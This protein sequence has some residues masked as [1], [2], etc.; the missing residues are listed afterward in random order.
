MLR[1]VLVIGALVVI[2]CWLYGIAQA[3]GFFDRTPYKIHLPNKDSHRELAALR[4][5]VD[6]SSVDGNPSVEAF[7]NPD[8]VNL[9]RALGY[10]VESIPNQAYE[11]FLQLKQETEGS[12]DPMR[13]YHSYEELVAEL[14]AIAS[15]H[16]DLCRAV[17]IGPTVQGRALWFMKISDNVNVEEDEL[18]FL[19]ISSMHGDEVV[20]KE[21]CMYLINLLVDEYGI[22]P[23][24]TEL[25]NETEIWI[26]PSMNPDGTAMGSRYNANGVDLNRNFPDR[27]DDPNNTTA[28]REIE[29]ANVMNWS[30]AHEP[31]F[32]ANFHGGALVANY[33]WDHSFDSQANYAYTQD[34][35]VLFGAAETYSWNNPSMWN[36]NTY[37]F[38]NG[39]VNGVRW[40]QVSGGMQDWN[41][42]WMGDMD[43]TMEL[44]TTK[45]PSSSSLPGYWEDNRNAMISYL[46]FAHRGILGLVTNATS[47]Q[48]VRA[49]IRIPSRNDFATYTD[50]DAGD[51][52][53][54][55]MNGTYDL[56]VTSFGYWPA[57]ITSVQVSGTQATRVDVALEPADLMNF[58][59][60]LHNPSGGGLAARLTLVGMPYESVTTNTSGEFTFTN[61]YEGEYSLRIENLTDGSLIQ[62]P[63]SWSTTSDSLELWGPITLFY[64]GFESGLSQWTAQGSWGT[65]GNAYVGSQSAADSPSGSYSNNQNISL[66]NN[67]SLNLADYDYATL[68]YWIIFNCE[69][70]YDSIFTEVNPGSGWNKIQ[71][72]NS[73][74]DWWSLEIYDLDAYLASNLQLRYRLWTDGSVTRDGGFIDEVRLCVA[75]LSPI[76]QTT[77]VTLTPSGTPI[78][79]PA[80]GGTFQ[81]NIQV[82]N[83]GTVQV[84]GDVWC[85]LTLPSGSP[86]GPT[87]G[88]VPITLAAGQVLSR[89]RT[90]QIPGRA[91]AGT[92]SYNA[93]FGD[94][95][96]VVWAQDS[97]PFEKLGVDGSGIADWLN[98]GD[99]FPGETA[100]EIALAPTPG[101]YL[102]AQNY[103]NPFNPT[104][105]IHFALP[106]AQH[107][108]LSVYNTAGQ[109]IAVLL[110]GFREA[111]WHE[112]TWDAADLA[113]GLYV[114]KLETAGGSLTQKAIL[115]K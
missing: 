72:Y 88:P 42:V 91:P 52:H 103:P 94:Y 6:R 95:P 12:D 86:Y 56:D 40:Y 2:L 67:S 113:T 17:N 31:I 75:S 18:E 54:V 48:P 34:Q 69:S 60:I 87:L 47:G 89:D 11:M 49:E 55:L 62:I 93:F 92:Y 101:E 33:P 43:I 16:P 107:V 99:L 98:S 97:F 3:S 51:Y 108:K 15:A 35:D 58:S 10:Q 111:G 85:N 4:L 115:I 65:S 38:V 21:M 68:S 20:G 83:N 28:G 9:L 7:L 39:V 114:Y 23:D 26:M 109:R 45:W 25:V 13:D 76:A 96:N 105:E 78:Q 32:S 82:A 61:I 110:D 70:N 106:E 112:V 100:S 53:R 73:T 64:D 84:T 102:L 90:Q 66:T 44:G 19:Y 41:Y 8:D 63:V 71:F 27:V 79:I 5:D 14:N 46:Q 24:L 74:Q 57:H 50:P 29:T 77:S 1:K 80:A 81:Y 22:D 59:G 104:T 37:P 36:N 30:F